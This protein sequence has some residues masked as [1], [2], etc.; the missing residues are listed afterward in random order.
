[1]PK[2]AEASSSVK[3]FLRN[4]QDKILLL[5]RSEKSRQ[6]KHIWDLPGGKVDPGESLDV[7]LLRELKEETAL[8]CDKLT[9]LGDRQ[10][11]NDKISYR[12]TLYSAYLVGPDDASLSDE[13]EEY[14]WVALE[15][16][17]SGEMPLLP[18][19]VEFIQKCKELCND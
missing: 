17:R 10:F 4:D 5:R 18:G 13:H 14:R 12:E 19:L 16:L 15:S 3:V 9:L 2:D 7:A 1:M 11:G 8:A 6:F